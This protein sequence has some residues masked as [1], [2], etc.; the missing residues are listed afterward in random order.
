MKCAA[1]TF[2]HVPLATLE[3]TVKLVSAAQHLRCH[4]YPEIWTIGKHFILLSVKCLIQ[5]SYRFCYR[6]VGKVA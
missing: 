5:S 1:C 6:G 4:K 2:A 3:Y